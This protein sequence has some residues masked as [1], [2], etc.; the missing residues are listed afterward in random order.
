MTGQEQS[1]VRVDVLTKRLVAKR[2]TGK[3]NIEENGDKRETTISAHSPS[4]RRVRRQV[5]HEVVHVVQVASQQRL[6][7]LR[8]AGK[9]VVGAAAA[10]ARTGTGTGTVAG[11]ASRRPGQ[12]AGAAGRGDGGG[13]GHEVKVEE[14]DE[15]ELDLARRR[16]RLEDGRDREQAVEGLK[17]AGVLGGVD[18]GDDEREQRGRLDGGT[19][20]GFEEIKEELVLLAGGGGEGGEERGE[21]GRGNARSCTFPAKRAPCWA[22]AEAGRLGSGLAC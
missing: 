18:E 5:A 9:V 17:G 16:P 14:L 4:K 3:G 12:L 7:L 11:A 15:L 21:K 8:R 22:D 1:R 2:E 19:V 6:L 13:L 20:D 10:L